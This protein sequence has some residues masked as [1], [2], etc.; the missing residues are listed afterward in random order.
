MGKWDDEERERDERNRRIRSGEGMGHR[1]SSDLTEE[2]K[3]KIRRAVD[4]IRS[5]DDMQKIKD[6]KGELERFDNTHAFVSNPKEMRK[7]LRKK[8]VK[9]SKVKRKPVKRCKCK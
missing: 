7:Y 2:E 4:Q 8:K 5:G 6:S 3:D 9:K 1:A